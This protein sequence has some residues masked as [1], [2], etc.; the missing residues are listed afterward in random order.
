MQAA[1][2]P[3]DQTIQTALAALGESDHEGVTGIPT[4]F[5]F[6]LGEGL[7]TAFTGAVHSL[8]AYYTVVEDIV[9]HLQHVQLTL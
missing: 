8:L 4:V 3:L 7:C 9:H 2:D 5:V 6:A 1:V